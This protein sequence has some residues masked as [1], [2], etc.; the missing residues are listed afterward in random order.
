MDSESGLVRR[1][2]IVAAVLGA[3]AALY[4]LATVGPW[5]ALSSAAGTVVG[6]LNVAVL[7]KIITQLFDHRADAVRLRAGVFLVLKTA[8]LFGL[9]GLIVTR[10]FI[11]GGWFTVGITMS[12]FGVIF[13]GL[14]G[15]APT[16]GGPNDSDK[17]T[18]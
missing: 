6:T 4:G 12:V 1:I 11:L 8:L 7:A 18:H 17:G 14:W 13:G 9:V 16:S 3:V 2:A 5:A 10:P 15:S